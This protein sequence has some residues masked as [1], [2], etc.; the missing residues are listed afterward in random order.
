MIS[1]KKRHVCWI[2]SFK[3]HQQC[4][5]LQAVIS[6]VYKVTHEYIV[7]VWHLPSSCKQLEHVVELS[8]DVPAD[9]HKLSV[10][11]NSIS[12]NTQLTD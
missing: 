6:S 10:T 12:S 5:N 9:L 8:M 4:E 11:M 3:E 2:A 7:G 1:S